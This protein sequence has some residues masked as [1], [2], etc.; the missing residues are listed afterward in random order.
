[1]GYDGIG[2][3]HVDSPSLEVVPVLS[4]QG[5]NDGGGGM[6]RGKRV[7]IIFATAAGFMLL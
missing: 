4:P 5:A 1:M 2:I 7:T 6:V 3:A